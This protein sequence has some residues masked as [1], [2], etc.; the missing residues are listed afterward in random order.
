MLTYTKAYCADIQLL[1]LD[2]NQIVGEDSS[3][4]YLVEKHKKPTSADEQT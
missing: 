4:I 3:K 1:L 2:D